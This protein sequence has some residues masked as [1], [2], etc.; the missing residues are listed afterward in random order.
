MSAVGTPVKRAAKAPAKK[1]ATAAKLKVLTDVT[2]KTCSRCKQSKPLNAETF[3][4]D[5]SSKDGFYGQ[6]KQC[7][8][9]YRASK[10]QAAAPVVAQ[11]VAVAAT[12]AP[13]KAKKATGVTPEQQAEAQAKVATFVAEQAAIGNITEATA[14]V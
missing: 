7:E 9:E 12:P 2:F 4:R 8:A 5:K 11:P 1:S 13:K 3:A 6:C 10:K 14:A